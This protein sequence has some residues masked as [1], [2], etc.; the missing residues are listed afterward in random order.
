LL[1]EFGVEADTVVTR[2]WQALGNGDLVARGST[3]GRGRLQPSDV[4]QRIEWRFRGLP[5]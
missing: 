5:S 3:L 4:S 2:S 1:V